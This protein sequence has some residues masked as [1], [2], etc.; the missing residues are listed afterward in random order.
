[1]PLQ[2][3]CV[4]W[5]LPLLRKLGGGEAMTFN[6]PITI[7]QSLTGFVFGCLWA[8]IYMDAVREKY[9]WFVRVAA[10]TL[11]MCTWALTDIILERLSK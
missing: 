8:T 6:I 5:N 10:F 4:F 9:P 2:R 11:L 1:M 3:D 7:D